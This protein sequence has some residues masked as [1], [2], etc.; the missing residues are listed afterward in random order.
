MVHFCSL[1]LIKLCRSDGKKGKNS[2][3]VNNREYL[4]LCSYSNT[5][6]RRKRKLLEDVSITIYGI[7]DTIV[8]VI[9]FYMEILIQR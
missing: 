7:E 8:V 6:L 5:L 4:I 2:C 9:G 3:F 1:R